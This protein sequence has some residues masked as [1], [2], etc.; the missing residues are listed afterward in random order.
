MTPSEHER[1]SGVADRGT[2][3]GRGAS[4][5]GE[6]GMDAADLIT[7]G[8]VSVDIYPLQIGVGLRGGRDVRQVSRRQPDQRRGRR[9]PAR[10]PLRGDHPDRG[11]PVR[12]LHPHRTERLRRRRPFRHRGARTA[13]A[14]D[15]LRDLPAGRLP[16]LLLPVPEGARPGDPRRRTGP[17]R[18]PGAPTCSGRRSPGCARNQAAAPPRRPAQAGRP[19]RPTVLDLDYRPMFWAAADD[20]R[21]RCARRWRT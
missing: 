15:V 13:D 14:G 11:R 6:L 17:R 21:H 19:E 8:R 1:A 2:R 5:E 12:P 7:M 9:R 4:E 18:D 10:A 20:A 3:S 16:A